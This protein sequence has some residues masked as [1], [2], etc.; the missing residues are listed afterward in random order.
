MARKDNSVPASGGQPV[1]PEA[2]PVGAAPWSTLVLTFWEEP[3]PHLNSE[4]PVETKYIPDGFV[5]RLFLE[6][7]PV[8]R[9]LEQ[10]GNELKV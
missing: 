10:G 1:L 7:R 5:S 9:A 3:R 6:G 2:T 4:I 8:D